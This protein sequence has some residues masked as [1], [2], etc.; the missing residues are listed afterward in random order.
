MNYEADVYTVDFRG[1]GASSPAF[2]CNNALSNYQITQGSAP[3][4]WSACD[5]E[6]RDNSFMASS[7]EKW[8]QQFTTANAARDYDQI[9]RRVN[10][11]PGA[12][13][14]E[15]WL[16][17]YSYG[18]MLVN[19]IVSMFPN[20]AT[21]I[22]F[23]GIMFGPEARTIFTDYDLAQDAV[24]KQLFEACAADSLCSSKIPSPT[25]GV[26]VMRR[27]AAPELHCAKYTTDHASIDKFRIAL[28][29]IGI[30]DF[31]VREMLP[32]LMY[33]I[34][35]CDAKLDGEFLTKI[36]Q[37]FASI[38]EAVAVKNPNA[39]QAQASRNIVLGSYIQINE[40]IDT[41][42]P[43]DTLLSRFNDSA[44]G[45]GLSTMSYRKNIY[46]EFSGRYTDP[47]VAVL[48]G[49]G[50][51]TIKAVIFINGEWDTQTPAR[52]GKN[53]FLDSY[54]NVSQRFEFTVPMKAHIN[55]LP[56]RPHPC[57]VNI[58]QRF[59]LGGGSADAAATYQRTSSSCN[60]EPYFDF[61]A[62][63]LQRTQL[64]YALGVSQL[65]EYWDGSLPSSNNPNGGLPMWALITIIVVAVVLVAV[66]IIGLIVF[67]MRKG[68]VSESVVVGRND[69]TP[70]NPLRESL[71]GLD[72]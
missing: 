37:T 27:L 35:R 63:F 39:R 29:Y 43:L 58:V 67:F 65:T 59:V 13:R 51:T 66:V 21:H 62:K 1:V 69:Q 11:K 17:G 16:A 56:G 14:Q 60:S 57:A 26:D 34:N 42:T 72:A 53:R 8:M 44:L 23:D 61:T 30:Q 10:S 5:R 33:R 46:P 70:Y 55:S 48:G 28:R 2:T 32:M 31:S 45:N 3:D 18:T 22:I 71:V 54:L 19:R 6:V 24:F 15:I 4:A 50:P 52:I 9:I 40:N 68:K 20:L 25:F 12:P 49:T 38:Y 64:G 41:V 47:D 7:S 36:S